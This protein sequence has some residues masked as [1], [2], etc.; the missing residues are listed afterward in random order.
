MNRDTAPTDWKSAA[1]QKRIAG[2]YAAERALSR[3]KARKVRTAE[4]PVL[5]E[6]TVAVEGVADKMRV[7]K[8]LGTPYTDEQIAK[9]EA[10][11]RAQ[12]DVVLAN[13]AKKEKAGAKQDTEIVAMI[14]YL[15]RL[16]RNLEPANGKTAAIEGGK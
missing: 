8:K 7:L 4:V 14:A 5:F 15:M 1:M 16:G 3:L 12:A 10:D 9:A 6:S 2:R 11:Y 13:L